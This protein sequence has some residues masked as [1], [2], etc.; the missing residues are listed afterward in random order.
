MTSANSYKT[1]KKSHRIK[2]CEMWG[3][4]GIDF[5]DDCLLSCCAVYSSTGSPTFHRWLLITLI[6]KAAS[7]SETSVN[8]YRSAR[9]NNSEDSHLSTQEVRD[10]C[11]VDSLKY[12]NSSYTD[13][14]SVQDQATC[15]AFRI[16]KNSTSTA[17]CWV[18]VVTAYS[19][20][21]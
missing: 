3:S 18:S 10:R 21:T 17:I 11:P 7:T 1:V 14:L 20:R 19:L 8:F 13:T 2:F 15:K 5:D 6:K 4:H 9:R 16:K 12:C